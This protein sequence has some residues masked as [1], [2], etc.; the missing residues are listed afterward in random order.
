[1]APSKHP[2]QQQDAKLTSARKK[3]MKKLKKIK[4]EKRMIQNYAELLIL[5]HNL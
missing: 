5:F 1:M 4:K 3:K 2:Q